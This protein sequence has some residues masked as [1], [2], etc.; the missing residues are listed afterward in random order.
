M[1]CETYDPVNHGVS[2]PISAVVW[3]WQRRWRRRRRWRISKCGDGG[4]A[5]ELEL[6][7]LA[8][9]ERYVVNRWSELSFFSF[10]MRGMSAISGRLGCFTSCSTMV[11]YL[12]SSLPHRLLC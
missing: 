6:A 1:S 7:V 5:V 4:A 8:D 10:P 12:I 3:R 2:C 9:R 11:G